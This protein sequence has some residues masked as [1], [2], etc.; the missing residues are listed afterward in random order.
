MIL[1]DQLIDCRALIMILFVALSRLI[2][3]YDQ[4]FNDGYRHMFKYTRYN[5]TIQIVA[6]HQ[7]YL[8]SL[9][10][11]TSSQMVKYSRSSVVMVGS[12]PTVSED[13]P[14][15]LFQSGKN[16]TNYSGCISSKSLC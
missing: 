3:R 11:I 2:K 12:A 4:P 5:Q 1:S 10:V 15:S 14:I 7:T 8:P 13:S 16:Y 9:S 6:D